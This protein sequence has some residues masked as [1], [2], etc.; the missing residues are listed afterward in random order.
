METLV[1]ECLRRMETEG[2]A[3]LGALCSAHP[4][5]AADLR[6]RVARLHRIGLVGPAEP[7][8]PDL[9]AVVTDQPQQ[10]GPYRILDCL[11]EG[12]MGTVYLAEQRNPVHRRAALKVIKLGMDSK[13]VLA[14]FDAERQALSLM[15]HSCIS[16]VYDAGV[17]DRGQPWFAMEFVKGIPITDY[18]DQNKLT[19]QERIALFRQVC[20]GVQHAHLKG[21]MH[22]DLKP[23]NVLVT[24]QDG[25][26]IPK[27]IDFGLAKAM[28]HRLVEATLF[29]QQGQIVGTPEYMSPEQAG[30]G[31]LDI[32]TRTDVYSLGVLLYELL[33]GELPFP[34]DDLRRAGYLEMQRIIRESDPPKPST[35]ITTLGDA[36][37]V[38]ARVRGID[39]AA[40][41]RRLRGDLDWIVMKALE[42]DRTRR[43]ETALEL[44]ADL[45]RHLQHVPVLASPPS[46][47][48]RVRKFVRRYRGQ[49]AAAAAVFLAIVGGGVG[50]YVLY[51]RAEDNALIARANETKAKENEARL[52]LK[53]REFEQLTSVVLVQ[54]T[55]DAEQAL[56]P[57][58]PVTIPA[59][60]AWLA[61]DLQRMLDLR[62]L[63]GRTVANLRSRG[64]AVVPT[65]PGGRT[66]VFEDDSVG[67]LH[68]NLE[69]VLRDIDGL[70][71]LGDAVRAN[72]LWAGQL[73]SATEAHPAGQR[74]E[75]ARAAIAA[76]DGVR[77]SE[78]YRDVP[79]DL[80]PQM[81]LVPIGMNPRT[82]LW[83]FYDLR[84]AWDSE[85]F[86]GPSEIPIPT[87]AEDGTIEVTEQTGIVF[88]LV[89][90]GTLRM[91][92]DGD[93]ADAMPQELP[94]N[95]VQLSPYFL[96]RHELTHAQ[97]KRLSGGAAPS[98]Y[99][100]GYGLPGMDAPI[101]A[102]HPVESVSWL[103]CEALMRRHG[104]VLP[105]EA[106][107]EWGCRG[108]V[109]MRWW[110]GNEVDS[111]QGAA[112]LMDQRA[113]DFSDWTGDFLPWDDG[114]LL[115]AP[116]GSLF[117]NPFG[118]HDVHGNVDEWCRDAFGSYTEPARAGDGLRAVG[119][120]TG[121]RP[122]R[123]GSF[124]DP[125][126]LCRASARGMHPP[127]QA[128][129]FLGVRAARA[130][131]RTP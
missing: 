3:A 110:T 23:S 53:V 29:T 64:R 72:L 56:G 31:G 89:P 22:R 19:L 15:E 6:V 130:V 115:S 39:A 108:G 51:V 96:A 103:A 4:E 76:A 75:V 95:N 129:R 63:L 50:M 126:R 71:K 65:K 66:I 78:R 33:T 57:A 113:K 58:W 119:D 102:R 114:F 80:A 98:Y 123:G 13:A 100:K 77:A 54:R 20:S 104:M 79:V 36:A 105:T 73:Q 61:N 52:D 14:R 97:W 24:V 131:S 40:L 62:P 74:W 111:L 70:E 68:D 21:V 117:D 99:T 93:D 5:L 49:C 60:E 85:H 25:K 32:D 1:A 41:R 112:N 91:G 127:T 42:K 121:R 128:L 124:G 83:E 67:F 81:G 43:Y 94:A 34:R 69:I 82:K 10:I 120:G 8:R 17:S 116:V 2:E 122:W 101:D 12:G 30:V 37:G 88:V 16:R 44:A 125:L 55:R 106:Q 92:A 18:C 27:I 107:W 11:G 26:P 90:G 87:H 47:G 45:E 38:P 59:M 48:Y 7:G 9:T 118:L 109:T 28:D 46:L 86:A 84:S 35:K